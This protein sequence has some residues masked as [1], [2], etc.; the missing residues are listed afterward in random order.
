MWQV[1]GLGPLTAVAITNKFKFEFDLSCAGGTAQV[2]APT[3]GAADAWVG[4]AEQFLSG[5]AGAAA[6][7]AG[8]GAAGGADT[9]GGEAVPKA[10]DFGEASGAG[11]GVHAAFTKRSPARGH[12]VHSADNL[13]LPSGESSAGRS[14]SPGAVQVESRAEVVARVRP[15]RLEHGTSTSRVLAMPLAGCTTE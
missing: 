11:V 12:T 14:A 2:R 8:G 13:C 1:V 7:E 3:M 4:A 15:P 5:D 10:L 9:G 6:A